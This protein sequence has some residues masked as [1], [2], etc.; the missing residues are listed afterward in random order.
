MTHPENLPAVP[1]T[2]H[3]WQAAPPVRFNPWKHHVGFLRWRLQEVSARGDDSLS[4]LASELVVIGTELM[5]LYTGELPPRVI[6]DMIFARIQAEPHGSWPD[7]RAWIEAGGGYQVLTL[8]AD[9]SCWVLRLGDDAG[10]YVHVHP[11]RWTLRTCRVR[12]NALKTAVLALA[13]VGRHGGDALDLGRVNILRQRYLGLS[14]LGKPLSYTAGIGA[15][16]ALLRN[17]G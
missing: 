10:R 17:E 7:Y 12:A 14:P 16:I 2:S 8:A 5:D 3:P 6:G 11:G 1:L 15:I 4:V 9:D 13:D